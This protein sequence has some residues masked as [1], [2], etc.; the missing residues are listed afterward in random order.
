MANLRGVLS[1][2]RSAGVF[3]PEVSS[4]D[5]EVSDPDNFY[6]KRLAFWQLHF[7]LFPRHK[8]KESE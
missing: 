1:P 6:R 5:F 3:R 8:P 2:M 7:L 4:N